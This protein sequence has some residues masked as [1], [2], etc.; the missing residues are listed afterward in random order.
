M[1]DPDAAAKAAFHAGLPTGPNGV[2]SPGHTTWEQ[3]GPQRKD[4]YRRIAE[5]ARATQVGD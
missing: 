2:P 1:H 5:A 3:L 4:R